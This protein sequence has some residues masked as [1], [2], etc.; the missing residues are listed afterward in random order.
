[1]RG[2]V[3]NAFQKNIRKEGRKKGSFF[4]RLVVWRSANASNKSA[5]R[6]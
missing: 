5:P 4:G 3:Q 1:M 6:A 2:V